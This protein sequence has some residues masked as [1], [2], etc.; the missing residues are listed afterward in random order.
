MKR[1]LSSWFVVLPLVLGACRDHPEAPVFTLPARDG[2]KCDLA[3][4]KGKVVL[5]EFW[6]SRCP[7]CRKQVP[8][9]KALGDKIDPKKVTIFAIHT[10]GGQRMAESLKRFDFGPHVAVCLDDGTVT[11][12]YRCARGD[13]KAPLGKPWCIR[14]IPHMLVVDGKGRIQAYHR[15]LTKADKLY[16]D[17]K[18]Y[19]Q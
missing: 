13:E 4:E 7:W 14:G 5:L 8:E 17:L 19:L 10:F 12:K 3:A 18:R 16:A 6:S 11:A 2:G 9:I 15:G 1:A